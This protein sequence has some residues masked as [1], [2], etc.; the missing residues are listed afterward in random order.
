MTN[1]VEEIA[2]KSASLPP[3]LQNEVL[4]FVDFVS[5][6]GRRRSTS[7]AP[8]TSVRGIL[9]QQLPNLDKDLAEIR[10]EMWSGFPREDAE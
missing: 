5:D 4:D 8:F 6:K 3:E 7:G 9:K 2:A 10:E 1:V